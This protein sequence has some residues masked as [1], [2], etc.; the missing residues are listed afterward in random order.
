MQGITP[1]LWFNENAEEAV[2]YYTGI[3]PHSEVIQV[4]H[5]PEGMPMPAGTVLVISFTLNGNKFYAINGGPAFTFSEGI[6]LYI[7]C[8][9]QDEIDYYW[10]KLGEGGAEMACGWLK[11]KYGIAWQ[12]VPVNFQDMIDS[13]EPEKAARVLAAMNTMIKFDITG[14]EAAYNEV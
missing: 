9:D 6:S 11:D 13:S 1:F 5:Y 14:L 8:D 10:E 2:A 3:F 7:H 4:T 12:I